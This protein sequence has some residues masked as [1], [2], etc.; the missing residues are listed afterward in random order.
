VLAG[1]E[2]WQFPLL[3]AESTSLG[4]LWLAAYFISQH[5]RGVVEYFAM[6]LLSSWGS[7]V[8]ASQAHR[9][10]RQRRIPLLLVALSLF[11]QVVVFVS[12]HGE[13]G[14]YWL[15]VMQPPTN[16]DTSFLGTVF[17]VLTND[18]ITHSVATVFAATLLACNC[19]VLDLQSVYFH[20]PSSEELVSAS[21]PVQR[22]IVTLA[23]LIIHFYRSILPVV[24]W[25][26]FMNDTQDSRSH[27]RAHLYFFEPN[28]AQ[29]LYAFASVVVT[30]YLICATE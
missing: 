14:A 20:L 2:Q 3:N 23:V 8:V 17:A 7:G 24:P 29:C 19:F 10:R 21:R 13:T 27:I 28:L 15:I 1:L 11:A 5:W 12:C 6:V 16:L 26:C 9:D 4:F 25:Y 22:R 30:F 18:I